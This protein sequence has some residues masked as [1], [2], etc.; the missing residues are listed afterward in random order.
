MYCNKKNIIFLGGHSHSSHDEVE[1]HEIYVWRGFVAL[2]ALVLFFLAE[3]IINMLGEW[4][5]RR[6]ALH[7]E[8]KVRIVR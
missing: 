5:E 7:R 6:R 4:R 3:K 1:H 8:K 2:A